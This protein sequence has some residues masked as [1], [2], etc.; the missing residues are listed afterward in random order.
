MTTPLDIRYKRHCREYLDRVV[1]DWCVVTS[2]I[3]KS[4][5]SY[6]ATIY[7]DDGNMRPECSTLEAL[8]ECV[9]QL[10]KEKIPTTASEANEMQNAIRLANVVIPDASVKLTQ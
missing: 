2:A 3:N 9:A 8:A 6:T 1:P 4:G 10:R 7:Q 5:L